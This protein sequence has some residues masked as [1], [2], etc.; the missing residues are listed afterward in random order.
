MGSVSSRLVSGLNNK[1]NNHHKLEFIRDMSG[2]VY[3][4][5][6]VLCLYRNNSNNFWVNMGGASQ[7]KCGAL[8][9]AHG[10]NLDTLLDKTAALF[11]CS[12]QK[13]KGNWVIIA[14]ILR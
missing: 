14:F 8:F 12:P 6:I 9:C 1:K 13:T 7:H 4:V 11:V 3:K 10:F 2:F 5:F